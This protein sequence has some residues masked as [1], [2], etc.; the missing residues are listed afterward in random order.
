M[1]NSFHTSFI[2]KKPVLSDNRNFR[3]KSSFDILSFVATLVIIFTI[4]A[5]VGLYLYKAYMS[6]QVLSKVKSLELIRESLEEKTLLELQTFNKRL[7][8]S[9]NLLAKH[10]VVSPLFE[11]LNV[12]TLPNVQFDTFTSVLSDKGLAVSMSGLAKDYRT[13]AVQSDI[14]NS[15]KAEAFKEVKFTDLKLSDE[16][17]SKGLVS[18]KI[19]FFVDPNF[20]SF[21]NNILKYKDTDIAEDKEGVKKDLSQIVDLQKS[22]NNNKEKEEN[23]LSDN[24]KEQ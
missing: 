6:K 13:I 12:L 1:D 23:K 9:K 17:N 10:I 22:E 16:K 14:F 19:S 11:L 18:F 2:P 24:K 21:E 20:I 15:E 5:I 7:N 3:S 4:L 8:S